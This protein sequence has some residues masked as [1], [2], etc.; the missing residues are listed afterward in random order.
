MDS[1]V[2]YNI[3]L[4]QSKKLWCNLTFFIKSLPSVATS[5][6][7]PSVSMRLQASQLDA[8]EEEQEAVDDDEDASIV[9]H[10]EVEDDIFLNPPKKKRKPLNA[11]R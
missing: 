6:P 1:F 4:L 10:H 9:D 2:I 11:P 8:D 7:K 5:T 3:V